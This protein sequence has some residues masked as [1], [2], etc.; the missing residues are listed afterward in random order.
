MPKGFNLQV[1]ATLGKMAF[2][3]ILDTGACRNVVS[4]KFAQKVRHNP[5]TKNAFVSRESVTNP[6]ICEGI[7]EGSETSELAMV[8]T[9]TLGFRDAEAGVRTGAATGEFPVAFGELEGITE[10]MIVGLPTLAQ[11]GMALD[12]DADGNVWVELRKLGITL[13]AERFGVTLD[14]TM[15]L[16][17]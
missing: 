8:S 14:N 9:L 1:V 13:L 5:S 12:S 11:W 16:V 2:R 3:L 7:V 17:N 15:S 4:A 10:N 6:I